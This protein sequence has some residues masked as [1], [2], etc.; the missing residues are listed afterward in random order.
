MSETFPF[1][2]QY[3]RGLTPH[4]EDWESD[5]ARMRE[6][7]F[8]HL[9]A[10]LVWGVLEPEPG[11]VDLGAI[12]R[13]LDLAGRQGLSVILLF[14]LHGCPEWAIRAHRE[15]WYVDRGGRPFEPQPRSNTPSGGWPGL[16]PDHAVTVTLETK[17]IRTVVTH[18]G[19]HPALYA[20]EPTNEPH[21][22]TDIEQNPPGVFCYCPATRSAFRHWLR[23][24]YGDLEELGRAWGRRLSSWDDARP[25]TW[26][27]GYADWCDWRTFTADAIAEHTRRRAEVIRGQTR[28]RVIAHAW[29][30]GTALCAHLGAMAFDDWKHAELVDIW[31]CSGFPTRLGHIVTL[32]LSMDSTRDA[33]GSKPFWQAELGAGDYGSGLE[34]NGRVRPEWMTLWSWES[35]RH[36]AKGLLYWQFRKERQGS[37]LGAYGLTDYAGEP[38]ANAH[39][40]AAVGRVLNRCA[41][42]FLAAAPEPARVAILFSYQSY[43][44]DWA[45]H[46]TCSLS[47]AA[48]SGCYRIFWDRNIPVDVVHEERLTADRLAQYRLLLLP[49]PTALDPAASALL[50]EYVARGGCVL[51]DPYLCALTPDKELDTEIPGRGL[52]NLFGCREE[53]IRRAAGEVPLLL[54]DGRTGVVRGSHFQATWLPSP[55][56]TVLARYADG[57]P[58]V[59][60][61]R[62][63]KGCALIS[64]LNLG[65]GHA[66]DSSLGDD[67]RLSLRGGSGDDI[68]AE[69]VLGIAR[70]AGVRAPLDAPEG[71]RAGLL[72]LP[73]GR[74]LLLALN[75]SDEPVTG[76]VTFPERAFAT[77]LRL[78]NEETTPAAA[79]GG[80][81]IDL[82]AL[83]AA[84]FLLA[85]DPAG[86]TAP[87]R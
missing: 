74:A 51:S 65:M 73:D 42:L 18:V 82:A 3:L 14:H 33:A 16:C 39:A 83:S 87:A 5:L 76:P 10:W 24:R 4:P 62:I 7:G 36:G 84:V 71:I 29:G 26:R 55:E 59:L 27:F 86:G 43:M 15:C 40:V 17:F 60:C 25:P 77:A 64:G 79:A 80:V 46:R 8:T 34:R 57:R 81:D 11:R 61:R 67:L 78:D 50:G 32:G 63:G 1:G 38:T 30:G 35:I 12:D 85:P 41:D 44:V 53:D 48:L 28:A 23:A 68:A 66:P 54:P 19:H 72:N 58:A 13:L 6:L 22:W 37:E 2:S 69:L 31:G 75:L 47:I 9:R 52:A 21:M 49:T 70:D 45:E 56:C 20:W